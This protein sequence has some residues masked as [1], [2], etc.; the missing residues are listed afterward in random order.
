MKRQEL[1]DSWTY[2]NI[3]SI[4]GAFAFVN[5]G[6]AMPGIALFAMGIVEKSTITTTI[7]TL[8]LV[9]PMIICFFTIDILIKKEYYENINTY[10]EALLLFI[11]YS[12]VLASAIIGIFYLIFL[13]LKGIVMTFYNVYKLKNNLKKKITIAKTEKEINMLNN[14]NCKVRQSFSK[15]DDIHVKAMKEENEYLKKR[16]EQLLRLR[17]DL[18]A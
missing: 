13:A 17:G 9:L 18:N 11:P 15:L 3:G 12:Y 6:V 8:L 7:G 10:H 2:I 16:N 1:F 14:F 4:I 5:L